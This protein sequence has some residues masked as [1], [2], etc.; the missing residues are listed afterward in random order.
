[1]SQTRS[2]SPTAPATETRDVVLVAFGS[3]SDP[4]V[5]NDAILRLAERV[6]AEMP[7]WRIRGATLGAEGSLAAGFDRLDPEAAVFPLLMSD[8]WL[9]RRVLRDGLAGIG[10]GGAPLLTP[11]GL[12][13]SFRAHCAEMIRSALAEHGLAAPDTSVVL[14]AHGSARGPRPAACARALS[15]GLADDTGVRAVIPGYLEEK[16]FLAETLRDAPRPAICLP[17]FVTN[18]Y[19]ATNDVPHAVAES[20]FAGPVLPAAGTL[21]GI[22]RLIA[23]A[24][25]APGT[26]ARAA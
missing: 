21:P 23:D 4:V 20:G 6:A 3:L 8:G 18:A 2:P 24:L 19:H 22:P 13:P 10:R 1:M 14:A 16:P 5:L 11:L 7:D 25:R 12:L 9:L 15:Q 17:C 26:A